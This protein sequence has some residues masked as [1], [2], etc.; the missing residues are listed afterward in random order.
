MIKSARFS[1]LNPACKRLE[2]NLL[3]WRGEAISTEQLKL[4]GVQVVVKSLLLG[5]VC[6]PVTLTADWLAG[7]S[8]LSLPETKLPPDCWMKGVLE[9]NPSFFVQR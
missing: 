5:R 6:G 8:L 4:T 7:A 1:G 9:V 2:A 3:P